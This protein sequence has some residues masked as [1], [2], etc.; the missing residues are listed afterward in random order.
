MSHSCDDLFGHL[1]QLL[2]GFKQWFSILH[3]VVVFKKVPGPIIAI[4]GKKSVLLYTSMVMLI[5]FMV[6]KWLLRKNISYHWR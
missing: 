2:L 3:L 5:F 4:L 6:T 1:E